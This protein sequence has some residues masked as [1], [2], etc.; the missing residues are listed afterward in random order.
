[1]RWDG[2]LPVS[3]P[4]LHL[5]PS[6]TT[7]R[8]GV[9]LGKESTWTK[10][11]ANRPSVWLA[12]SPYGYQHHARLK[13]DRLDKL[14]WKPV[15]RSSASSEVYRSVASLAPRRVALPSRAS[16]GNM[17]VSQFAITDLAPDHLAPFPQLW[18]P[19]SPSLILHFS[20]LVK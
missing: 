14:T 1:M 15:L 18:S 9:D 4:N 7:H 8:R 17:H 11:A 5:Q 13:A 6:C 19:P 16:V 20:P 12:Q 2:C 10:A 3:Q